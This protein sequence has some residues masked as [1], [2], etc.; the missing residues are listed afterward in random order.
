MRNRFA[1]Q[2]MALGNTDTVIA[3]GLDS[4][5]E[6]ITQWRHITRGVANGATV[7]D[8]C[9]DIQLQQPRLEDS[10]DA[11]AIAFQA[12]ALFTSGSLSTEAD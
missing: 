6:A 4:D 10:D 12:T 3:T 5:Y 9:R 8:I 2:L 7:A 11:H 1:H